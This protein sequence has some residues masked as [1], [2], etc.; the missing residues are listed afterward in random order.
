VNVNAVE[1]LLLYWF[2]L[3]LLGGVVNTRLH[4]LVAADVRH[5]EDDGPVL[6][7]A[8]T[9]L[10]VFRLLLALRCLLILL[11]ARVL[12]VGSGGSFFVVLALLTTLLLLDALTLRKWWGRHQINDEFLAAHRTHA[13]PAGRP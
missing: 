6:L 10:S 12:S 9:N 13:T 5:A 4:A 7:Q 2:V 3:T 11:C 8:R 1:P